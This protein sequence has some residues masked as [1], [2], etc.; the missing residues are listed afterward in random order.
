MDGKLILFGLFQHVYWIFNNFMFLFDVGMTMLVKTQI[1]SLFLD[2]D[3]KEELW[4]S[5]S[6]FQII[7]VSTSRLMLFSKMLSFFFHSAAATVV[8][9]RPPNHFGV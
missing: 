2:R 8:V 4:V 7:S 9:H 1:S 6:H 5:T 3:L